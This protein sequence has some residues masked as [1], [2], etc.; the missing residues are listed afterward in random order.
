MV[1]E[2]IL[3][4]NSPKLQSKPNYELS[5][6]NNEM[7]GDTFKSQSALQYIVS[8]LLWFLYS[9]IPINNLTM[10]CIFVLFP[11]SVSVDVKLLMNA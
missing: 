1:I 4:I 9:D 6:S 8:Y 2:N 10:Y 3:E 11:I 5:S 7:I